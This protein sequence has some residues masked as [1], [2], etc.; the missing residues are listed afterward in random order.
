M[1]RARGE[2]Q[3]RLRGDTRRRYFPGRFRWRA[4]ASAVDPAKQSSPTLAARHPPQRS[5]LYIPRNGPNPSNFFKKIHSHRVA[6]PERIPRNARVHH[7]VI[8]VGSYFREKIELAPHLVAGLFEAGPGHSS[9]LQARSTH[10][11][12]GVTKRHRNP[13]VH[14][15]MAPLIWAP[16]CRRRAGAATVIEPTQSGLTADEATAAA[17]HL[18]IT[19]AGGNGQPGGPTRGERI[20]YFGDYEIRGEVDSGGRAEIG[21]TSFFDSESG[22]P[23]SPAAI[24]CLS[25]TARPTRKAA[26]RRAEFGLVSRECRT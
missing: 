23:T 8:G 21:V 3:Y 24:R 15:E 22:E 6:G 5:H 1:K 13:T 11:D 17:D 18:A 2:F 14:C 26:I 12:I 25:P 4:Q 19:D 20:R 10:A 16:E 9:R 7:R